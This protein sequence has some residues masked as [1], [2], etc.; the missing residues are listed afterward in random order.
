MDDGEKAT[1]IFCSLPTHDDLKKITF[2]LYKLE[3]SWNNVDGLS[4]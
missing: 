2:L 3:K 1:S 4:V